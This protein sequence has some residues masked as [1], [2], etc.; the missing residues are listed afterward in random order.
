LFIAKEKAARERL[1]PRI[2]A[3]IVAR[4]HRSG[5]RNEMGS[6]GSMARDPRKTRMSTAAF[7]WNLAVACGPLLPVLA[8]PFGV[9]G[10]EC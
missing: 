7:L 3:V 2:R 10:R 9:T 5:Q 4:C 6:R 8:E 1:N